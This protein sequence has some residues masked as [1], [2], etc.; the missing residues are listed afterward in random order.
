MNASRQ[1]LIGRLLG[2]GSVISLGVALLFALLPQENCG[3]VISEA[4]YVG[5]SLAGGAGF[6]GRCMSVLGVASGLMWLFLILFLILAIIS[7][8][9][10]SR[11]RA[12]REGA[13]MPV[14][15]DGDSKICPSCAEVVRAKAVVCKHCGREIPGEP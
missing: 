7:I 14:H 4:D 11:A 3:S 9:L 1:R 6:Y 8:V 15:P 10:T 5:T 12:G 2:L 13:S